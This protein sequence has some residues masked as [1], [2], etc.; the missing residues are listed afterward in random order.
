MLLTV[1]LGA[2]GVLIG[3]AVAGVIF[4]CISMVLTARVIRDQSGGRVEQ[5]FKQTH[6]FQMFYNRR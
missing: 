1:W 3:Q 2:P 6:L 4:G 5:P